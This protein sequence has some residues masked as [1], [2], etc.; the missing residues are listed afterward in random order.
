MDKVPGLARA[1]RPDLHVRYGMY[2]VVLLE[3]NAPGRWF[4]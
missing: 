2:D 1:P 3:V 4:E